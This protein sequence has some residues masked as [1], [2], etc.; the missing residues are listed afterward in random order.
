MRSWEEGKK[1]R[2]ASKG[3]PKALMDGTALMCPYQPRFDTRT[4]SL[5][6]CFRTRPVFREKNHTETRGRAKAAGKSGIFLLLRRENVKKWI[7]LRGEG[8]NR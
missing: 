6:G 2:E 8:F 7:R 5:L 3:D 4:T 1:S